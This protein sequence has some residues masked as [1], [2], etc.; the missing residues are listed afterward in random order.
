MRYMDRGVE[1]NSCSSASRY[2]F[3]VLARL[4]RHHLAAAVVLRQV[5]SSLMSLRQSNLLVQLF[6]DILTES[7]A[8]PRWHYILTIYALI[9][10]N[11]PAGSFGRSDLSILMQTVYPD[12]SD[13]NIHEIVQR[14]RDSGHASNTL[15]VISYFIQS[16]R[17]G[18]DVRMSKFREMMKAQD[19]RAAGGLDKP[20]FLSLVGQHLPFVQKRTAEV[21]FDSSSKT[22]ADVLPYEALLPVLALFEVQ[23]VLDKMVQAGAVRSLS[24]YAINVP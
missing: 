10:G 18:V 11:A 7:I 17:C 5:Y 15:G 9:H 22:P 13:S 21:W 16:L 23:F 4:Y 24:S 8:S 3:E 6:C 2:L 12:A 20:E 14:F 19:I 1:L